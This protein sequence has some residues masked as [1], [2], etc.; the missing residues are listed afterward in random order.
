MVKNAAPFAGPT[1]II[2]SA[3]RQCLE[4]R[5]AALENSSPG[6]RRVRGSVQNFNAVSFSQAKV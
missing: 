5:H 2:F 1:H 4:L 6:D 3:E